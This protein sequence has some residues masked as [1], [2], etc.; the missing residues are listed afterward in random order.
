LP[1]TGLGGDG[2]LSP[3]TVSVLIFETAATL[4]MIAA[5]AV[6]TVAAKV[7]PHIA[8]FPADDMDFMPVANGP[9]G[10]QVS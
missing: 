4:A 6:E 7:H 9:P 5:T 1:F 10:D 3:Q 8:I 2:S